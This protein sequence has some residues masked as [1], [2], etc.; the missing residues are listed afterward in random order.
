MEPPKHS[1]DPLIIAALI[2]AGG[3]VLVEIL[4]IIAG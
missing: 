3:D 1:T 4:K 2:A